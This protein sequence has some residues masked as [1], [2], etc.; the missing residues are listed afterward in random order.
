[1]TAHNA[2][3]YLADSINSLLVQTLA[4][5]EFIIRE[6]ASTDGTGLV[7]KDW[8]QRDSRM[9]LIQS[10]KLVGVSGSANYVVREVR[11]SVCARMD[12]DDVL[13][14]PPIGL[15]R[16][17]EILHSNPDVVLVG[18]L[19]EGIDAQGLWVRSRN[20]WYLMCQAAIVPCPHGSIM[21]CRNVFEEV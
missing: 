17:W 6:D 7:L 12:A 11:A 8:A 4:D 9:R 14:P 10:S 5:F 19:C 21:F 16:Q 20:Y 18:T 13:A 15:R 1:M 3:P 2:V